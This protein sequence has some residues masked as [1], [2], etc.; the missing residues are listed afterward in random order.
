[1]ATASLATLKPIEGLMDALPD[2]I[3]V[4]LLEGTILFASRQL[5]VLTGYT[6]RGG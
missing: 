6:R 5:E 2:G 1:M 4:I 3:A